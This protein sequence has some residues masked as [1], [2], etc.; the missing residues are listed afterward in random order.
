MAKQSQDLPLKVFLTQLGSQKGAPGGGAAAALTGA[1]GYGLIEMV[2][3][4]NDAKAKHPS[5]SASRAESARRALQGLIQKDAD[6]FKNIQKAW[7]VRRS[8]KLLWQSA[9]KKGV[10]IP[11]RTAEICAHAAGLFLKEYPRTSVWL[12]SDLKEARILLRAAFDAAELNVEI[13]LKEI[14]DK[15][16]CAQTRGKIKKWR[17]KLQRS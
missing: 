4:I 2:S 9:L 17:R 10:A 7:K 16:F 11:L 15:G 8:K 13:N 1:T 3:R 14:S 5:G 12:S 6:V